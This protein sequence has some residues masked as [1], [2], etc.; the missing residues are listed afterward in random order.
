MKLLKL[1][2]SGLFFGIAFQAAAQPDYAAFVNPFIGTG[3]HG[4]TYPGASAPYGMV[5]LSPDTRIDGSWDG[6]GGYHY[7]DTVLFGFSHTHLSGTG[8]SDYGDV[9]LLPFSGNFLK[10]ELKVSRFSHDQESAEPG[11]YS[12]KLKDDA[13]DVSLTA[14][15]RTGFHKY[16]FARNAKQQVLI[17]LR[18]RDKL[19]DAEIRVV[20]NLAIQGFRRSEAWAKDQVVYFYIE[21]DQPFL[22]DGKAPLSGTV[23]KGDD[24]RQVFTFSSPDAVVQAKVALSSVSE[25]NAKMNLEQ[26]IGHWSFDRAKKSVRDAWNSELSRI[27]VRGGSQEQ[28]RVFYSALYHCMVVPNLYMDVNGEYRGRDGKVHR[29]E[30]FS[31]YT[32][33]SLWDTFRAYH[34]LMTLIDRRR[35]SDFVRTFLAQYDQAGLLPVWELSSNE[36]E[37]MIGYHAVPVMLEAWSK[38]VRSFDPAKAL[39]AMRK[40]AESRNR[41]GLG[42]YMDGGR[43]TMDDEHESVSKTLEYA[44]DDWCIAMMALAAG[45]SSV[46]KMYISRSQY[47]KNLFDPVTG[48]IR[49]VKNGSWLTPFD[50]REVNNNFTEANAWQ[51]TFF[52]PQDI[53]GLINMLG[54]REMFVRKL[55]ELFT[56]S[57]QTTGREQADITGLIGQYA[58]GNEPSHHMAYLYNYAGE[59][60]KTQDRVRQ[61][62]DEF[63]KDAP[64]G[65]IGNEDCGQMSA[66][67]VMSSL[68]F[69][70]VTPGTDYYAIG[71]PIF[72]EVV[73]N[74]E[75]GKKVVIRSDEPGSA[76]RYIRNASLNGRQL[77]SS[78]VAFDALK[79]GAI[80]DF[81]M[82]DRPNTA[83]G[84]AEWRHPMV[85]PQDQIVKVPV[86][87]A[88]GKSF[89]TTMCL[90]LVSPVDTVYYTL[91]GSVPTS[92][93]GMFKKEICIAKS[94]TVTAAA[95]SNGQWSKPVI[96]VYY[97]NPHPGWKVSYNCTYSAQYAAGGNKGLIDG[98]RGS[99]NWRKGE[100]QGFQGQDFEVVIDLG[101]EQD[102][103]EVTAGFLQ[104]TQAW[105]LFPLKFT[106][107]VSSN[108][109]D[110]RAFGEV[111]ND[112]PDKDMQVRLKEFKVTGS[113][114]SARYVKLHAV[115]YGELPEWHLGAGGAAHLFVDEINIR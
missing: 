65:L 77:T 50:P 104:D 63:Y 92:A 95:Y 18:H 17:D 67:Y 9:L 60:W 69:Y 40:S 37:C 107:S 44:Y 78:F 12:V 14:S 24:C 46:Y 29:A 83:W 1:I 94:T 114:T 5:Q 36:T 110:F 79:D 28:M 64:D 90:M 89:D 31:Y 15:S 59:P 71:T 25:S 103:T 10:S 109:N 35:T 56:S 75:N 42:Y 112:I 87:M 13:I 21:F 61:I 23:F 16:Q 73:I 108:G 32:V 11:F 38:G 43:L 58:H 70:A 33:F 48:F 68:G 106:A 49:P 86:I 27:E 8:C 20:N 101:N 74:L 111:K 66:W 80:L 88:P 100:W 4:H 93:S 102:V 22:V 19:L 26:E 47:W 82:G 98:I 6:C 30:G 99:E 96:G 91:D 39:E 53:P 97:K 85:N 81:T 115:N 7:S 41:Y 84:I 52:V 3:G 105:I 2:F 113:K 62:L 72:P 55:D 57:S 76:N 45:D 51:Y 34:P 54:G